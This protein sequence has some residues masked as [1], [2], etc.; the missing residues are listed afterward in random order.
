MKILITGGTGMCG[1]NILENPEISKMDIL[2]PSS[3]ELDL[4]DYETT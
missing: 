3:H 1:K 4:L 2:S